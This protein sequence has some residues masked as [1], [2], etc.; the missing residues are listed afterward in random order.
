MLSYLSER[1]AEISTALREV[2]PRK[3]VNI[4]RPAKED[5]FSTKPW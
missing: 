4:N 1:K 3:L 5:F 2:V